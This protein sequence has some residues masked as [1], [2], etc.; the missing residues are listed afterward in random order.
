MRLVATIAFAS[1]IIGMTL[2]FGMRDPG[3]IDAASAM[4]KITSEDGEFTVTIRPDKPPVVAFD[5]E[6]P[7]SSQA[8]YD[9][10]ERRIQQLINQPAGHDD[11]IQVTLTFNKPVPWEDFVELRDKVGLKPS[12]L[13]FAERGA[14][15]EKWVLDVLRMRPDDEIIPYVN[16]EAAYANAT[17]LGVI[18]AEASITPTPATLGALASDPRVFAVDTVRVEAAQLLAQHGGDSSQVDPSQISVP[19]PYWRFDWP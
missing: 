16:E 18:L 5:M 2:F 10:N 6:D 14:S 1:V 11:P 19:S 12:T 8:Y 3:T 4:P 13:T 9:A 15:G 17:V 7:S